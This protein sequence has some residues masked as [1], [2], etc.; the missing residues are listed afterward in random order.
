MDITSLEQTWKQILDHV[1]PLGVR[2]IYQQHGQLL[3]WK[4]GVIH[5]R[6]SCPEILSMA[7]WK[8]AD[9]ECACQQVFNVPVNITFEVHQFS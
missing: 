9:L 5:I 7:R 4:D 3:S 8:V 6:M 1:I 2:S